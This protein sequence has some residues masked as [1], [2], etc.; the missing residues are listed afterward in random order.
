MIVGQLWLQL[1]DYHNALDEALPRAAINGAE[2]YAAHITDL[3][4]DPHTRT[5]VALGENALIGYVTGMIL[6]MRPEMF[7]EETS[8]MISDIYVVPDHRNQG[9]GM[10]LVRAMEGFFASRGVTYY[11]W[12]VA[13]ANVRGQAFWQQLG[14]REMVVRMRTHIHEQ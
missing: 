8:G 9:V 1:V 12:F 10:A 13:S 3:M 2:R 5:Y 6:D 7:E 14:G 4:D 11:E